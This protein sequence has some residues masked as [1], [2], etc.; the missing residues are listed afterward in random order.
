MF[1]GYNHTDTSNEPYTN[2]S[3]NTKIDTTNTN[4]N[5]I[6]MDYKSNTQEPKKYV[7]IKNEYFKYPIQIQIVMGSIFII[8]AFIIN[9]FVINVIIPN[10]LFGIYFIIITPI[11]IASI[12]FLQ[13]Y[14]C[15]FE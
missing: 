3:N 14:I 15:K 12:I 6:N 9:R 10:N 11:C 8:L 7:Q 2:I 5:I 1:L 13:F 4:N